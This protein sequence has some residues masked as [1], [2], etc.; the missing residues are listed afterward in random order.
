MRMRISTTAGL[1]NQMIGGG[2]SR[3]AGTCLGKFSFT[4]A[5]NIKSLKKIIPNSCLPFHG[6]P[7]PPALSH[8]THPCS[9]LGQQKEELLFFF[10][11]PFIHFFMPQL[12]NSPSLF[13][14]SRFDMIFM[15]FNPFYIFEGRGPGRGGE[16]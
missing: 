16:L 10:S 7:P 4:H 12:S 11:M 8:S 2:G 6:I 15:I 9:F 1:A 14:F 3:N 5:G 13:S